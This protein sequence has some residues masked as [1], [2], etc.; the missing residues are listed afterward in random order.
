MKSLLCFLLVVVL[1]FYGCV[2]KDK[3]NE[4]TLVPTNEKVR[5]NIPHDA[6]SITDCLQYYL[7]KNGK[8]YLC[9]LSRYNNK[10][11]FYNIDS[12][13]LSFTIQMPVIGPEGVGKIRGFLVH[14]LDTILLTTREQRTL[15]IIDQ[16][17]NLKKKIPVSRDIKNGEYG[18]YIRNSVYFEKNLIMDG[19][20]IFAGTHLLKNPGPRELQDYKLCLQIDLMNSQQ[21]LLPMNYPPLG[22]KNN[23]PVYNYFST[24]LVEDE[25]IYSF[26]SSH[27]LYKTK[28]HKII[29]TIPAKSRYIEK[30]FKLPDFNSGSFEIIGKTVL[31]HPSYRNFYYDK[32]RNVFY[33]FVYPGIEIDKSDN[34]SDLLE[35]RPVFSIMILD[36]ELQVIGEVLMPKNKY[37]MKMA[38][39]G[40]EGL[41]IST[42]H[43]GNPDFSA[44]YLRFELFKLEKIQD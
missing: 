29:E 5:F 16:Y 18:T 8:Q 27:N 20:N 1:Y 38:F 34:I 11:L 35:Y 14:K 26:M 39:V 40:K 28:D 32:Y 10:L 42:N 25:F 24:I 6:S 19:H 33:R 22:N 7:T 2:P 13:T 9:Y 30:D 36:A 3:I 43:T 17:G 21:K 44:D 23:E 15:Y 41:Y 31:E 37:N 12:S 4:Y